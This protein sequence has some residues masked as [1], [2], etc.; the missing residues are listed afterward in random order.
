MYVPL[1]ISLKIMF[2]GK[3]PVS[4]PP[5]AGLSHLEISPCKVINLRDLIWI[6][7]GDQIRAYPHEISILAVQGNVDIMRISSS[8]PEETRQIAK[9]SPERPGDMP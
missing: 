8:N 3:P 4:W 9:L 6:C 7:H 5:E 2:L 1:I